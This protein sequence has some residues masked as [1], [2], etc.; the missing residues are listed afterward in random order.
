[1]C[2]IIGNFFIDI[3]HEKAILFSSVLLIIS[4]VIMFIDGEKEKI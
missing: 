4:F 3:W 1:M 2:A